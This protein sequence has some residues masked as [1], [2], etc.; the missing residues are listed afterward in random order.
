LLTKVSTEPPPDAV[1]AEAF[2]ETGPFPAHHRQIE[3]VVWGLRYRQRLSDGDFPGAMAMVAEAGLEVDP[4]DVSYV[5]YLVAAADDLQARTKRGLADLISSGDQLI[6]R[7]QR[8]RAAWETARQVL[9]ATLGSG[10]WKAIGRP[11]DAMG[12]PQPGSVPRE[13]PHFV[14][15]GPIT[16]T[17]DGRIVSDGTEPGYADVTV[18]AEWA[19]SD[20]RLLIAEVDLRTSSIEAAQ[21][22]PLG[23]GTLAEQSPASPI[24]SRLASEAEIHRAISTVYDYAARHKMK[25]PNIRQIAAPVQKVLERHRT[26]ASAHHIQQLAEDARHKGRRLTPGRTVRG[27]FQAFSHL[28]I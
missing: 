23:E 2:D 13:I 15:H 28:E 12:N 21:A 17:D 8:A 20:V 6:D 14:W 18:P 11:S 3:R 25:P 24:P 1:L 7:L 19:Y 10:T 16:L 26:T 22:T 27:S 4:D 9:I 5:D